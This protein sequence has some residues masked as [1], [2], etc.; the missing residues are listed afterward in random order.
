MLDDLLQ[1][2]QAD[3]SKPLQTTHLNLFILFYFYSVH[4]QYIWVIEGCIGFQ[5][6]VRHDAW[7]QKDDTG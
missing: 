3:L 7:L 6:T 1:E 2:H 4:P 5:V